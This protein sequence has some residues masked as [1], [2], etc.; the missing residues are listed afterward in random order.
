MCSVGMHD[1]RV[2]DEDITASSEFDHNH[3]P[4]YARIYLQQSI[5]SSSMASW[6]SKNGIS[7]SLHLHRRTS[8]WLQSFSLFSNIN[9][10]LSILS[11][12]LWFAASKTQKYACSI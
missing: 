10:V 3:N 6:A 5:A 9:T 7:F 4:R 1:G 8:T 11:I 12:L 2:A